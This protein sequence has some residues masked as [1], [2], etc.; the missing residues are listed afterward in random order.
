MKER[1]AA[2][3]GGG[4]AIR[5]RRAEGRA[6]ETRPNFFSPRP[7]S[8]G[9]TAGFGHSSRPEITAGLLGTRG[10]VQGCN[11]P[12]A[13]RTHREILA[14]ALARPPFPASS[15]SARCIL[16]AFVDDVRHVARDSRSRLAPSAPIPFRVHRLPYARQV[17]RRLFLSAQSAK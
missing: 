15:I 5:R 17:E 12:G 2:P 13:G 16:H 3:D 11:N 4:C 8:E 9:G 7:A 6:G 10:M 1:E 14:R